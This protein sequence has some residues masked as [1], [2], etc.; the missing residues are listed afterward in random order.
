MDL[1]S[2]TFFFFKFNQILETQQIMLASF[3]TKGEALQW[4]QWFEKSYGGVVVGVRGSPLH[5][6]GPT[7]Y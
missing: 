6:F 4:F 5:S 7:M 2:E 3:H 1:S